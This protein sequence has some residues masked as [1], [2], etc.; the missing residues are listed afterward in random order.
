MYIKHPKALFFAYFETIFAYFES[1]KAV[2]IEER[3]RVAFGLRWCNR[4]KW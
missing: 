1:Q 2:E 3:G 4:N